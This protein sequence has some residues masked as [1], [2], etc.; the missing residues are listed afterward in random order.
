MLYKFG[1]YIGTYFY[2]NPVN[3]YNSTNKNFLNS[4]RPYNSPVSHSPQ[5]PFPLLPGKFEDSY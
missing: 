2:P 5:I 3:G 4:N 1:S